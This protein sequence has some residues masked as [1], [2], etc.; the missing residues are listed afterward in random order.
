MSDSWRPLGWWLSFLLQAP[1]TARR[2]PPIL[3]WHYI[4]ITI[5]I[6]PWRESLPDMPHGMDVDGDR[7]MSRYECLRCG[8]ITESHSHPG[9][10]DCGGTYQNRTNSLE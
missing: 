6:Y 3:V 9:G 2:A 1:E 5:N 10:C 7:A 8:E 4:P